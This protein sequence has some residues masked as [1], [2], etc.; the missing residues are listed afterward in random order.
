[1]APVLAYP[2]L[3]SEFILETDASYLGLVVMLLQKQEDGCLHP[4]S[5]ASRA[6]PP[7]EKNYGITGLG[8]LAVVLEIGHF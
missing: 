8:T 7:A 4:V 6:L 1:M 2:K 5:Y 3:K